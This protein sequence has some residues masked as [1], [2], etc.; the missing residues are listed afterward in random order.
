MTTHKKHR[1]ADISVALIMG[2]LS[3]ERDVSLSTGRAIEESLKRLGYKVKSLDWD[4]D[5][6]QLISFLTYKP[7]I[8]F[9]ALHGL[10]GED[11]HVQGILDILGLKYTHSSLLASAIAMNKPMA[12]RLCEMIGIPT[13]KGK[14]CTWK[15]LSGHHPMPAPYVVKPVDEGSSVGVHIIKKG[16]AP[17]SSKTRWDFG[18]EVL[19]EEYIPGQELACA[20]LGDKSLGIIELRPKD[21]FYDYHAKY[22]D[23]ACDHI[24]PA[25]LPKNV[26]KK[27]MEYALAAHQTLG[28]SGV[29]RSDFR[30]DH[31]TG[32]ICYLETNTQP[33]CTPVSLLPEIAGNVGISF[34]D[35]NQQLIETGLC[36]DFI[37]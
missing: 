8:V 19:V 9:N 14:V 23:G 32:R 7:D 26:Y 33:G 28:C 35:L 27:I 21:E 34:D 1:P 30:Y 6:P 12:K 31:E 13:A 20:V 3:A 4:K 18:A 29:S 5:I 22:T 24:F 11:G 15:E 25:A 2:G 17:L 36:R 37:R 10:F 16:E